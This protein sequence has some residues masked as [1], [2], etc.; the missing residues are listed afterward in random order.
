MVWGCTVDV[1]A[2]PTPAA[3]LEV[4]VNHVRIPIKLFLVTLSNKYM[5]LVPRSS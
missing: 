5:L 3:E 2:A 1:V 4:T